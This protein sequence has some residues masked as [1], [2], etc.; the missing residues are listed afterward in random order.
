MLMTERAELISV[1]VH[2][3][4]DSAIPFTNTCL[5]DYNNRAMSVFTCVFYYFALT[6]VSEK[7]QKNN[8]LQI[9]N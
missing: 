7:T 3:G 2:V 8:S 4:S 9:R 5:G 1:R 6:G